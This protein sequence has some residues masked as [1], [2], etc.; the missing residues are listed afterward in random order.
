MGS[1]TFGK[2]RSEDQHGSLAA[3]D[4]RERKNGDY[5]KIRRIELANSFDFAVAWKGQLGLRGTTR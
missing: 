1:W 4:E 3:H 2:H 5:R